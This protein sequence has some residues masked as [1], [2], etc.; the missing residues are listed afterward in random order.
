LGQRGESMRKALIILALLALTSCASMTENKVDD[1]AE[2]MAHAA[3]VCSSSLFGAGNCAEAMSFVAIDCSY[4]AVT[5][6]E[7]KPD[8][9]S[10][11][12]PGEKQ[13]KKLGEGHREDGNR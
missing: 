13:K 2:S 3:L 10:A 5:E 8:E 4:A 9:K 7:A 1:C 6:G 12:E 11:K